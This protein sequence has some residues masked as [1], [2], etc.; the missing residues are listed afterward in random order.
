MKN[1]IWS[2]RRLFYSSFCQK[3]TSQLKGFPWNNRGECIYDVLL[4]YFYNYISEKL[5]NKCSIS[6]EV[7]PIFSISHF[8]WPALPLSSLYNISRILELLSKEVT[9]KIVFRPLSLCCTSIFSY[10]ACREGFKKKI[11]GIRWKGRSNKFENFH[12]LCS[13][14]PKMNLKWRIFFI[15][16]PQLGTLETFP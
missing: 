15:P 5:F 6:P 13:K 10:H 8:P 1:L 2:W 11:I 7:K 4:W 12:V 9:S 14:W 3:L 16:H